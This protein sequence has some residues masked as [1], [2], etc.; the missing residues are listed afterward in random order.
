MAQRFFVDAAGFY[1][2]SFDGLDDET[3]AAI[4]PSGAIEVPDPP[5]IS[6]RQLWDGRAWI[7]PADSFEDERI[8]SF[9]ASPEGRAIV[10]TLAG[11]KGID[12]AALLAELKQNARG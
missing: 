6:G 8:D 3:L 7:A 2:G 1:V 12:E 10:R 5:P 9:A 11:I 4:L